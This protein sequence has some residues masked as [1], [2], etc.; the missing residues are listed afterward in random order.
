M[1]PVGIEFRVPAV[2]PSLANA[3]GHWAKK[4]RVVA[5][6]VELG[7]WAVRFAFGSHSK[8]AC[9]AEVAEE[10]GQVLVVEMTRIAPRPLDDDNLAGCFKGVRDGIARALGVSDSTKVKHVRWRPAQERGKP[11]ESALRVRFFIGEVVT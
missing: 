6:H 3:R 2:L 7:G 8:G 9:V 5:Q 10:R 1:T 11:R 4:A